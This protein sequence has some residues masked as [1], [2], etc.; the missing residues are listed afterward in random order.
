MKV[1]YKIVIRKPQSQAE[2][3]LW[4]ALA[5]VTHDSGA[6]R[7]M[8]LSLNDLADGSSPG[9]SSTGA[10]GS[11]GSTA[12]NPDEPGALGRL[13]TFISKAFKKIKGDKK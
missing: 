9:S 7:T 3:C 12:S 6:K 13:E 1:Q 2:Q 8:N 4:E 10:A 11:S 5:D